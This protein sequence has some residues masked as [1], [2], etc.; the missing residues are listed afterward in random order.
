MSL[1]ST[2]LSLYQSRHFHRGRALLMFQIW[3]STCAHPHTQTHFLFLALHIQCIR[4]FPGIKEIVTTQSLRVQWCVVYH[5]WCAEQPCSNLIDWLFC[6]ALHACTC[7]LPRCSLKD[8][9]WRGEVGQARLGLRGPE[10]TSQER[11]T[12]L[13]GGGPRSNS[14]WKW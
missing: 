8:D 14:L 4:N 5:F 7:H 13:F 9:M 6:Y 2:F 1:L 10:P 11:T 3:T 12:V